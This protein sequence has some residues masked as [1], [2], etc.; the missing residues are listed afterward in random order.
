MKVF[1]N[2]YVAISVLMYLSHRG[3]HWYHA[4]YGD[5]AFYQSAHEALH[6]IGHLLRILLVVLVYY[7]MYKAIGTTSTPNYA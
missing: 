5:T 4:R 6:G 7:L 3:L 1:I 2:T